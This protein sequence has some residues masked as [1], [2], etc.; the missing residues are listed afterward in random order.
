MLNTSQQRGTGNLTSPSHDIPSHR[1]P[2]ISCWR[3]K[4]VWIRTWQPRKVVADGSLQRG[5]RGGNT[6]G[7]QR[8]Q[9]LLPGASLLWKRGFSGCFSNTKERSCKLRSRFRSK[10]SN[11]GMQSLEDTLQKSHNG[12]KCIFKR[13]SFAICLF[14][15]R[16]KLFP[17]Q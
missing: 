4:A 9:Q 6:M 7:G 15:Q 1:H 10:F 17:F 16:T 11:S 13:K 8:N 3:L 12:T 5:C 14:V 2:I